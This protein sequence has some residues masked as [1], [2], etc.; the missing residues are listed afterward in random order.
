M[1]R[2]TLLRREDELDRGMDFVVVR[3]F[4]VNGKQ[5]LPGE[6]F[7]TSQVTVRRLRQMYDRRMIDIP[8]VG[9]PVT[10]PVAADP[11]AALSNE[12]LAAQLTEK[13]IVP[14]PNASREWLLR[15]MR[16]TFGE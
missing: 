10:A 11:R 8:Q 14:R 15:K 4:R 13:G 9:Q 3:G 1:A 16:E 5:V 2:N 6:R 7:D 12:A